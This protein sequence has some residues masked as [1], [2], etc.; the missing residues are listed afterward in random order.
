MIE[1]QVSAYLMPLEPGVYCVHHAPDSIAPDPETGLPAA[2]LSLPPG[3][4]G[5]GVTIAG[6]R[7]D[8]WLGAADAAALVRVAAGPGQILMTIYQAAGASQPPKLQVMKL[9]DGASARPLGVAGPVAD[10]IPAEIAAHVQ[11]RGDVEARL[12]E[13]I[14]D[15][16]SQHW[17][18]GFAVSPAGA[19]IAATDIEYQAVLGRDWLSPWTPGPHYCGSRGMA[20]A[21]L[22]LRV[23]LRGE[24]ATTHRIQLSASFTDG[25]A[26]G[27]VEADEL[28]EAASL[29]PLEAF[30]LAIA[31]QPPGRDS[32][33]AA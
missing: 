16:G 31:R 9:V 10:T 6:F 24:A 5:R 20:L 26:I 13:W 30:Q 21:I 7:D 8:G 29:A 17:M 4:G 23:R 19:G 27:P 25:T 33:R 11:H 18:E 12:G 2:R 22:G 3:P 15:R 14:G 1:L 28:C 32:G